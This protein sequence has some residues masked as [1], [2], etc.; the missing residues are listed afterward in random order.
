MTVK[1]LCDAT[2]SLDADLRNDI[3]LI[4]Y[5]I[6]KFI[7]QGCDIVYDI[8]SNRA[9]YTSFKRHSTQAFYKM[10]KLMRVDII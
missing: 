4:N 9:T 6:K 3:N 5:F 1:D 8:R 2:I 7:E 10:D